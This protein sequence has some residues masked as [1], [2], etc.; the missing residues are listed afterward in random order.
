MQ[1]ISQ[2]DGEIPCIP[3]NFEKHISFSLMKKKEL[4]KAEKKGKSR[5]FRQELQ[6]IDSAQL[7]LSS[8]DKVVNATSNENMEITA[9]YKRDTSLLSTKQILRKERCHY[10]KVCTLTNMLT[11]GGDSTR[12]VWPQKMPSI[13]H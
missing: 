5:S 2:V 4:E 6:F 13:P 12:L 9:K 3:N 1:A 10:A 8:L 7:W 11:I